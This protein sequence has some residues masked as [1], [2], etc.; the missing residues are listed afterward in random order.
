MESA[1]CSGTRNGPTAFAPST[2]TM[3][4]G[5]LP[6]TGLGMASQE[7][8]CAG[9]TDAQRRASKRSLRVRKW[10]GNH[11]RWSFIARKRSAAVAARRSRSI[12]EP[13]VESSNGTH[14]AE[15]H[16]FRKLLR[17]FRIAGVAIACGF[18]PCTTRPRHPLRP[19]HPWHRSHP[20]CH[21]ARDHLR[22]S[23]RP[24]SWPIRRWTR[25]TPQLQ[26]CHSRRL[27]RTGVGV[28]CA[29]SVR[30]ASTARTVSADARLVALT[31]K[32]GFGDA[33]RCRQ[34]RR[35]AQ[36]N[37]PAHSSR[38]QCLAR[39][40]SEPPAQIRSRWDSKSRPC[41]GHSALSSSV[42]KRTTPHAIKTPPPAK[43][44]TPTS[45][46]RMHGAC[47]VVAAV[48]RSFASR[49]AELPASK[50]YVP[51]PAAATPVSTSTSP[52]ASP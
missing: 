37:A 10:I 6:S 45:C 39:V 38:A 15:V 5:G 7:T 46:S 2:Y 29:L 40:M 22:C 32:L 26:R 11:R 4:A 19:T 52:T 31:T 49:M 14:V 44:V 28:E 9:L 12:G 13:R 36:A 17:S 3:G 34:S 30:L 51:T 23:R 41:P 24:R 8:A 43:V 48:R 42:R 18:N 21:L 25:P 50:K 33:R 20:R 1:C 47:R 27:D 35:Q 16:A